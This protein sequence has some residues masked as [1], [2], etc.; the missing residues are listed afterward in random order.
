MWSGGGE[1]PC[2]HSATMLGVQANWFLSAKGDLLNPIDLSST[3]AQKQYMEQ[4]YT[5]GC[6]GQ[7]EERKRGCPRASLDD[8][9]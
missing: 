4:G 5:R 1:V 6:P 9:C 3:A 2:P 7:N 8:C